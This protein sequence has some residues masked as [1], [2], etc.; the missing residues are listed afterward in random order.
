MSSLMSP[1][2]SHSIKMFRLVFVPFPTPAGTTLILTCENKNA[3]LSEN[4]HIA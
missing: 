3:A 2:P 1:W 4:Y